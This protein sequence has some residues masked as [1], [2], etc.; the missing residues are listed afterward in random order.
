MAPSD[1]TPDSKLPVFL[2]IQGGGFNTNSNPSINSSGL[3]KAAD[4]DMVVVCFNYR[5][6]PYGF[7]SDGSNITPNIGLWDQ[8]KVM[9]WVQKHISSF[10]GDPKH[11]TIGG[12]SAGAASVVFHL[13][14]ENGTDKNLFHA[15]IGESPSFATTLTQSESQYQYT[16]FATRLGC[17]G[18]D[19]L[20]C[21]RKKTA[22]E[23]QE[24]NFNIPLPGGANAP[25]YQW[26]PSLDNEFVS[27]YSYRSFQEG[28]FVKVPTIFGDDQNGGTKFAPKNT[29]TLA[30]SNQWVLDQYPTLTLE[31]LGEIDRLYPNENLTCPNS[32]CYW[33]QASDVYGQVRYM[34]PALK[35]TSQLSKYGVHGSYAYLWNVV[36]PKEAAEGLGVSHTVE[37]NALLGAQYVDDPP[38]SYKAGGVN[39]KATPAIQGYWTSF[40]RTYDP[41]KKRHPG[42]ARWQ[43]W[44]SDKGRLE[45]GT[46]GSTT[47][48]QLSRTMKERCDYWA[49]IALQMLL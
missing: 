48:K 33:R 25:K 35:A 18:K 16:Q 40:I 6:G 49:S 10:G 39:E 28:K 24:Q 14:A 20:S 37:L 38:E 44:S 42:T 7:I 45:F 5:V 34:C 29:S 4:N 2:Y 27:D 32:G 47:M 46:G 43:Q 11:V 22:V 12:T 36:D 23:I 9:E 31:Q 30:Q 15:A 41:N 3:I 8:R 19:S 21:L 13:T 1:A 26:L 17:V